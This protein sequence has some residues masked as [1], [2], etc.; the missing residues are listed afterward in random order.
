MRKTYLLLIC[1]L[2]LLSGCKKDVPQGVYYP[3][4]STHS[5][6]VSDNSGLSVSTGDLLHYDGKVY[7]S[8]ASQFS[9]DKSELALDLMGDDLGI[10]YS[11]GFDWSDI[12]EEL[13]TV[14][15]EGKVCQVKGYDPDF[16]VCTYGIALTAA[17]YVY[18]LT[19][20][21]R[22]NDMTVSKGSEVFEDRLHLSQAASCRCYETPL[23]M[24]DPAIQDLLNAMNEGSFVDPE[25]GVLG[26][27]WEYDYQALTF[28]DPWGISVSLK[29]YSGGYVSLTSGNTFLLAAV[30]TD[31]CNRYIAY[32]NQLQAG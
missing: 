29:V 8:S 13:Y 4:E 1:I 14:S 24:A 31:A 9:M 30:D 19:V 12:P 16:R 6:A 22:L 11:S 7:V 25:S 5:L 10:A 27:L 18:R 32:V 3:P 21:D 20:F 26:T 23:S 2:L 17:G 28:R 15:F